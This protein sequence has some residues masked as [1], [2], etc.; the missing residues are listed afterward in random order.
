MQPQRAGIGKSLLGNSSG[1]ERI[2]GIQIDAWNISATLIEIGEER[3]IGKRRRSNILLKT[4]KGL[5]IFLAQNLF[6]NSGQPS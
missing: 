2:A 5:W 4:A 1:P 6:G 3:Q